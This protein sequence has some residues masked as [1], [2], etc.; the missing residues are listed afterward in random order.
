VAAQAATQHTIFAH[1][2]SQTASSYFEPAATQPRDYTNPNYAGGRAYLRLQVTSKPSNKPMQPQVCFWRH[3][4]RRFQFETCASTKGLTFNATGTYWVDLGAPGSW[5]KLNGVY[6]W[7]QQASVVRIMLKDPATGTLFLSSKCGQACYSGDDLAD[8][9]PVQMTAELIMVARGATLV[10]PNNWR[11]GCP[12]TWS[13]N[14]GSTGGGGSGVP[15]VTV[16][17]G[18]GSFRASWPPVPGAKR[19]QLKWR[20]AGGEVVREPPFTQTSRQVTG[21]ANGTT[22]YVWVRAFTDAWG[23]WT[24]VR[25][26]L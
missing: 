26:K 17:P 9:V 11:A 20:A 21:L 15:I 4:A 2:G 16:T 18:N 10:P 3:G 25:V 7:S 8:H 12:K 23:D 6:D 13:P 5:W 22:Y 1:S 14:C 19:Y 24:R